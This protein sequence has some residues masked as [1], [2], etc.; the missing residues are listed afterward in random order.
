MSLPEPVRRRLSSFSRTVFT[1]NSR[2]GPESGGDDVPDNEIVSSL[3]L[4]MSLY[5]NLCFFPFWWLSNI[6]MLQLKYPVLPDY[7]KFIL[8]TIAILT[9]LIEIIRLYLGYM[10]NLQEKVPELAGFWLL[11]I[12]LQLPL[13][14][15]L[16][17][18][19]GLKIQPLERAVNIIFIVFLSFQVISAFLALKKMVNQLA[20]RFRLHEFDQLGNDL[21]PEKR[22]WKKGRLET[23]WVMR[24]PIEEISSASGGWGPALRA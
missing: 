4:Q 19:E 14:L 8:V 23:P 5:F 7:Y 1:D 11:S 6:L 9:S 20:T 10:G 17:L 21:S 18:N 16:L 2:T 15:F 3:P 24:P 12:L 22:V 13:I